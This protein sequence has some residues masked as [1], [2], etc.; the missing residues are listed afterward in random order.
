VTLVLLLVAVQVVL[1]LSQ[2][3]RMTIIVAAA[4]AIHISWRTMLERADA[5]ALVPLGISVATPVLAAAIGAGMLSILAM[6]A[7]VRRGQQHEG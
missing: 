2:V 4:V 3:P 6:L 1:K 5:L 7:W